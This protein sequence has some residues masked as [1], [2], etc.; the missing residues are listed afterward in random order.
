M[1]EPSVEYYRKRPVSR[2]HSK[3]YSVDSERLSHPGSDRKKIRMSKRPSPRTEPPNSKW[4]KPREYLLLMIEAAV[5][6]AAK[7]IQER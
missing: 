4:L 2:D 5:A 3:T 1:K 7:V 6:V